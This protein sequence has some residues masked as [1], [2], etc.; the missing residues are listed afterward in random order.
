MKL[1]QFPNGVYHLPFQHAPWRLADSAN[2]AEKYW[3]HAISRDLVHWEEIAPVRS[4]TK[5]GCGWS[6]SIAID[7][8]NTAGL[9]KDPVKDSDG[10]LKNPA[11]VSFANYGGPRREDFVVGFTYSLDGGYHWTEYPDP[12]IPAQSFGNRDPHILWYEDKANPA[13]SH[14]ALVLYAGGGEDYYFFTSRDLAHWEKT[15]DYRGAGGSECPDLFQIPLDGDKHNKRWIFW[16]ANGNYTI[17]SFDGRMFKKESGPF[18]TC[19]NGGKSGHDY[20]AQA[21][22][23]IPDG[24]HIYAAWMAGG[25]FPGMPFTQ[26]LTLPRQVEL[27]TTPEGPRFFIQPVKEVET[28]RTGVSAQL[29]ASLD[30][31]SLQLREKEPLGELVDIEAVF[32]LKKEALAAEGE[33]RVGLEVNGQRVACLLD[34]D[35]QRG[36][37]KLVLN[38]SE[39]P[40]IAADGKIRLRVIVDRMSIEV[41]ANDGAVQMCRNFVPPDNPRYS[42]KIF[43]KKGLA[44]VELKAYQLQSIWKKK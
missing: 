31:T 27:R 22:I 3:A 2:I 6:G 12:V 24:R 7:W 19:Y 26:Q 41:F 11:L 5:L 21:F 10:R 38:D 23:N 15:G 33:N 8:S 16:C 4:F 28:L 9:V 13:K 18:R 40:L 39:A 32:N 29:N 36:K 35:N 37:Q 1:T 42:I 30:G 14:W 20:A 25:D 17:G 43:G 44:D 34:K